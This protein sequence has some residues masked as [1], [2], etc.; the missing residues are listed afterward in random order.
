M[1]RRKKPERETEIVGK[2]CGA[3]YRV[4]REGLIAK[5]TSKSRPAGVQRAMPKSG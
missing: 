3:L 5:V 2:G 4:A 1:P